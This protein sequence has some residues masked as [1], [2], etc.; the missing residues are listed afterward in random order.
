MFKGYLAYSYL[1]TKNN[2]WFKI[3]KKKIAIYSLNPI[4]F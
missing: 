1:C 3:K 2:I 4:V